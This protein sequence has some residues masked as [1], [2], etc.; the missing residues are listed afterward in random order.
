MRM[1][2]IIE[3]KRDGHELSYEEIKFFI[4][5]VC[6]ESI[7]DYQ[8]SA[9]LM[10]I[11]IRGMSARE[12]ADLTRI[13]ADSGEKMDL[14]LIK[15][16][17]M[18]KHSTGGV[19]DKT[20]LIVA[21]IVAACGVLVIKMSG[22]GLGYTGGTV[23]KLESIPG[24]RV[25]LE[26]DEIIKNIKKIGISLTGHAAGMVPADKK[27]YAL[28]DVTATVDSIP[29]IASSIMS[30]KIASGADKILLDV[31]CGSGAFMKTLDQA[32]TLAALMVDIGN[33]VGK[34]TVAVI[35]DMDVPLG[36][37]IGNS[38]EIIEAI[39]T[40]KGRG[41]TDLKTISLELASHMI[42]LAG[43]GDIEYCR[44]KVKEVVDNRKALNKFRE[45]IKAQGGDEEIVE[46]YNLFKQALYKYELVS[47]TEGYIESINAKLIGNASVILGAGRETKD[48]PV[49]YS[50]GIY[51]YKKIGMEVK[52]GDILAVLYTNKEN[53]IEEAVA[54]LKKSFSYCRCMPQTRPLILAYIDSEHIYKYVD[55]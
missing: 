10:A 26:R 23:D 11:F 16:V 51:L 13:M 41:P 30:K 17:K 50:A 25:A 5:G 32:I 43:Y 21:P 9:L 29:L 6:K 45:L 18:D 4:E 40:L 33:R 15:G 44:S 14:S 55:K 37:A 35:T 54:M 31:K 7:P 27:L 2:N 1:Y 19:G 46:N 3:K 52:K 42:Y 47:E 24:F 39:E 53:S 48:S 20:T 8:I 28:R 49:D 34:E 12:T 36:N 22:R 38:L